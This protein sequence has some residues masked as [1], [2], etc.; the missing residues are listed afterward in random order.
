MAWFAINDTQGLQGTFS[1]GAGPDEKDEVEKDSAR[2]AC[3]VERHQAQD[4]R[5]ILGNVGIG[6][7]AASLLFRAYCPASHRGTHL[8]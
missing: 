8:I 5:A 2:S 6:K 3:L 4:Q 1:A 7:V